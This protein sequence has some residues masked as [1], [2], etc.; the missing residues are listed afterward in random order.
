M[1]EASKVALSSLTPDIFISK[2]QSTMI[3]SE[4]RYHVWLLFALVPWAKVAS[5]KPK[6]LK[7]RPLSAAATVAQ[8]GL[9]AP[10]KAPNDIINIVTD[11]SNRVYEIQEMMAQAVNN[12]Y[13]VDSFGG[14]DVRQHQDLA[15]LRVRYGTAIRRWGAHW[16][17]CV[18]YAFFVQVFESSSAGKCQNI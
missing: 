14:E 16:R 15:S 6:M 8:N 4:D 17:L 1:H 18:M 5:A 9:K 11:A 10:N 7:G 13:L 12:S 2:F 3:H